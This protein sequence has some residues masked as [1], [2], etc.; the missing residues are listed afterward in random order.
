[1]EEKKEEVK[2]EESDKMKKEEEKKGELGLA[3]EVKTKK[4]VPDSK[5]ITA[6]SIIKGSK[7]DEDEDKDLSAEKETKESLIAM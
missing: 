2:V 4:A 6:D 3:G 7:S 5:L 1:M